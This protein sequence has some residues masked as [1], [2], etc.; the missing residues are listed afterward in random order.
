MLCYNFSPLCILFET[1]RVVCSPDKR[2]NWKKP[3]PKGACKVVRHFPGREFEIPK[4]VYISRRYG[5]RSSGARPTS[6]DFPLVELMRRE[7]GG[8]GRP[9]GISL[10]YSREF[11]N[12]HRTGISRNSCSG[13][14]RKKASGEKVTKGKGNEGKGKAKERG[15]KRDETS[16]VLPSLCS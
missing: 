1:L 10:N 7:R 11:T 13:K 8:M 9:M 12:E 6:K 4:G 5:D 16:L 15:G 2:P 14:S 3:C